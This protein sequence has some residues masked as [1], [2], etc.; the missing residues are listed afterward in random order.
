MTDGTTD[1]QKSRDVPVGWSGSTFVRCSS[2]W[3][4]WASM[5]YYDSANHS[6]QSCEAN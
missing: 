3:T 1:T 6:H 4:R 2:P 5:F